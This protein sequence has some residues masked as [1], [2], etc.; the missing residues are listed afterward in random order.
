VEPLPRE[1]PLRTPENTCDLR[2]CRVEAGLQEVDQFIDRLFRS[3]EFAAFIL[4]GHGTGA[5]KTAVR[6]HLADSPHVDHFEPATRDDG[7]DALT[8]F[9]LRG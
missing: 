5:M 3:N 2:G 7:G 8:V 9:W 4:H 6:Q 1:K